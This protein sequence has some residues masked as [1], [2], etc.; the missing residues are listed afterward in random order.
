M[1]VVQEHRVPLNV[2]VYQRRVRY[3]H[4]D[5]HDREDQKHDV[6]VMQHLQ[7]G[8]YRLVQLSH[9]LEMLSMSSCGSLV[10][11]Y[12]IGRLML[13]LSACIVLIDRGILVR[14]WIA[15]VSR[16]SFHFLFNLRQRLFN[17]A[18]LSK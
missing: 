17:F 11:L 16:T 12:Y 8:L 10:E 13:K 15:Q 9:G 5:G 1:K 7:V 6:H 14:N 4:A 3:H 2:L 18:G